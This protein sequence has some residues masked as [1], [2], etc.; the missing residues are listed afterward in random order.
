MLRKN[1]DVGKGLV[2]GSMGT[3][4]DVVYD[5][6]ALV[7]FLKIK[8]DNLN[9]VVDIVRDLRKIQIYSNA[10]LYRKQFPL[11]IAYAMTI[12]K[13]QGLSLKCIFTDVGMSVF[14][15]SMTYVC[16]SR[17]TSLD[18]LYL[19]SFAAS[20]VKATK[21][22]V[23]EYV[24]LRGR[25]YK[26]KSI[27]SKFK[28]K[29]NERIWYTTG[30]KRQCITSL[31][32]QIK[33]PIRDVKRVKVTN[34]LTP[35]YSSELSSIKDL[36]N[37]VP[38]CLLSYVS[39]VNYDLVYGDC[40]KPV[41]FEDKTFG[42][43]TELTIIIKQLYPDPFNKLNRRIDA[44]WL[45]ESIISTY[46]NYLKTVS[47]DRVFSFGSYFYSYFTSVGDART[48]A[49][50]TL[51]DTNIVTPPYQFL[52]RALICTMSDIDLM[53]PHEL[54]GITYEEKFKHIML[55]YGNPLEH[56]FILFPIINDNHWYMSFVDNRS[57]HRKFIYLDSG[58]GKKV[59]IRNATFKKV[60]KII[61]YYREH[62]SMLLAGENLTM[63]N[64]I[65]SVDTHYLDNRII[66]NID[67]D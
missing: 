3:L 67:F 1:L 39:S 53:Q 37:F 29:S 46:C 55:D 50:D 33:A 18:G 35:T 27:G 2:N 31:S 65:I 54:A 5:K 14:S 45:S 21:S 6:N 9:H 43:S 59:S 8:F 12:H 40:I 47:N 64:L 49:S 51:R 16:L 44:Q 52:M 48:D 26:E 62:L 10:Y 15:P 57:A 4:A 36:K 42:N 25:D 60:I 66:S 28:V 7:K 34:E 13:S 30:T 38:H 11:T 20:R 41:M 23:E 19:L 32:S 56:D 22:A 61:A 58:S 17:V 63:S 24:R